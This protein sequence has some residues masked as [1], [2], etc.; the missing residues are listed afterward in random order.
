MDALLSDDERARRDRF[1]FERDRRDFTAAHA[2]LRKA[3]SCYGS[4]PENAWQFERNAHGKPALVSAQAAATRLAFNLSHTH[5]IVACAV[6]R[7]RNVGIDVERTDRTI[8]AL[9]IGRHYFTPAECAVLCACESDEVNARF[10]ELWT[11]K[12]AYIKAVGGGLT[13][14]LNSFGFVLEGIS[15]LRF[16]CIDAADQWQFWLAS[17]QDARIAVAVGRRDAPCDIS[18]HCMRSPAMSATLLRATDRRGS[19]K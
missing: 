4:L 7:G 3:L 12:E 5:G 6:T 15:E 10:I 11:L 13:I 14:P 1:M 2:L 17:L 19:E 18:F 9:D 8:A 16:S